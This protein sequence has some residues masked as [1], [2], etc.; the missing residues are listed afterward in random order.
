MGEIVSDWIVLE[1]YHER[2]F[3]TQAIKTYK[4]EALSCVIDDLGYVEEQFEGDQQ[5]GYLADLTDRRKIGDYEY[6][7]GR[8]SGVEHFQP[9]AVVILDL[10]KIHDY[11]FQEF[12]F[13][14]SNTKFGLL[15]IKGDF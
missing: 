9:R 11:D 14:K 15:D 5:S 3:F 2:Y 7:T 8:V 12:V 6:E 4:D 13:G 1:L 10:R